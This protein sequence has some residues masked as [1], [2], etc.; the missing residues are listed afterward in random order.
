MIEP[1]YLQ[2]LNRRTQRLILNLA[3]DGTR[4]AKH[5]YARDR[6]MRPYAMTYMLKHTVNVDYRLVA[7]RAKWIFDRLVRL[8]LK[9]RKP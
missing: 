8:E 9:R 4:E 3:I 1:S 2:D 6:A 5:V 7:K